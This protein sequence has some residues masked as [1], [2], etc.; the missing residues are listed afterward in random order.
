MGSSVVPDADDRRFNHERLCK[1]LDE[2]EWHNTLSGR[3]CDIC[4]TNHTSY[5]SSFHRLEQLSLNSSSNAKSNCSSMKPSVLSPIA[6]GAKVSIYDKSLPLDVQN[7]DDEAKIG[8]SRRIENNQGHLQIANVLASWSSYYQFQGVDDS[9]LLALL[10]H[11]PITILL[12]LKLNQCF[13]NKRSIRIHYL[14]PRDELSTLGVF[15][16]IED[17]LPGMCCLENS[18][19]LDLL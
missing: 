14:G 12:G 19:F 15:M 5:I 8:S 18:A 6:Q 2:R 7:S 3:T 9:S 11:F 17:M 10:L 1:L 4:E 16:A 13:P